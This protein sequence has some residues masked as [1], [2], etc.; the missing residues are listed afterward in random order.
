MAALEV[1]VNGGLD[2]R[3]V[4]G[5]AEVRVEIV[6]LENGP[7]GLL[8][9]QVETAVMVVDLPDELPLAVQRAALAVERSQNW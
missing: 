4:A 9:R 3:E 7:F 6:Q 1:V 2:G 5:L 8:R